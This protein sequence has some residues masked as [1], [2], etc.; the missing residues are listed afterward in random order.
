MTGF[1]TGFV[2]VDEGYGRSTVGLLDER[3][4]K[5]PLQFPPTV[6]SWDFWLEI[7]RFSSLLPLLHRRKCTKIPLRSVDDK[8][9]C[10]IWEAAVVLPGNL[11]CMGH[12]YIIMFL[13][14][15]LG[16]FTHHHLQQEVGKCPPAL[17]ENESLT[18]HDGSASAMAA[19]LVNLNLEVPDTFRPPP[20]PLPYDVVVVYPHSGDSES[21]KETV[22]GGSFET[23]PTCEDLEESHC[24][25]H[26]SPLLLSP[27]KPEVTT[28]VESNKSAMEEED[29]CPI[30]LE[31]YD[32]E[33]PKLVTKC[34]HHFHLSCILEWMERSDTCPICDQEMIFDQTLDQ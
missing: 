18:T 10:G 22:S 17:E 33:N 15:M 4:Q 24:R 31:E 28:L 6:T 20:A 34:E 21:F 12:L 11:I 3:T 13:F 8:D 32:E 1:S 26:S 25:T 5:S 23:L 29:T 27:R 2:M 30:C 9:N 16:V 19:V 14:G 7:L